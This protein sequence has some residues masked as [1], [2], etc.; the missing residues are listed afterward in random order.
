MEYTGIEWHLFDLSKKE[1]IK[2]GPSA[3][4]SFLLFLCSCFQTPF[5][6]LLSC[7]PS[8][9]PPSPHSSHLSSGG[10][11]RR[12][13][14]RR[15]RGFS[16]SFFSPSTRNVRIRSPLP[17]SKG[18]GEEKGEKGRRRRK[19]GLALFLFSKKGWLGLNGRREWNIHLWPTDRQTYRTGGGGQ[20]VGGGLPPS[21]Q[22]GR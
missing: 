6:S 3:K 5:F 8:S 21:I 18:D 12:R 15:R 22:D 4:C 17:Y 9:F 16:L 20:E 7:V 2:Q 10:S 1:A 19:E 14:K 13:R 11:E